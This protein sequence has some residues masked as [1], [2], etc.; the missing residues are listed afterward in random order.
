MDT[1]L[2]LGAA[3]CW[4]VGAGWVVSGTDAA[5]LL[6]RLLLACVI[7]HVD[8]RHYSAGTAAVQVF[9][10]GAIAPCPVVPVLVTGRLIYGDCLGP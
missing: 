10:L 6:G 1:S 7:D 9:T 5:G 8:P 2:C 3:L 4:D